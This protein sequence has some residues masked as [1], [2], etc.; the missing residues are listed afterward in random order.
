MTSQGSGHPRRAS[1]EERD[2]VGERGRGR[3]RRPA[4][5]SWAASRL[6]EAH[7]FGQLGRRV[8]A[9]LP[10]SCA[11]ARSAP[12]DL[13]FR[14]APRDD[15]CGEPCAGAEV[16]HPL[17][18]PGDRVERPLQ[19]RERLR[20]GASSPRPAPAGRTVLRIKP[21]ETAPE[22]RARR[23]RRSSPPGRTGGRAP[24]RGPTASLACAG[25]SEPPRPQ[26]Y[27]EERRAR[28]RR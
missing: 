19:G 17:R 13:G 22:T 18:R 15:E 20:S 28:C 11:R 8:A 3:R 26:R 7:A 16:E 10:R 2:H 21:A 1:L 27:A 12:D 6:L 23:R 25:G 14:E 24:L 4:N 5:G 9:R